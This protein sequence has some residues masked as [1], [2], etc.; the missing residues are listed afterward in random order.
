[1]TSKITLAIL[2]SCLVMSALMSQGA[3]TPDFSGTWNPLRGATPGGRKNVDF[4]A[5]DKVPFQ[6]AT[7]AKYDASKPLSDIESGCV[8]RGAVRYT[9]TAML[10]FDI[11]QTPQRAV[12]L[13][14]QH[15]AFRRIYTDGR[16]HPDNL[17]PTYFGHSIGR[18]EGTTLVVDTIGE[19]DTTWLNSGDHMLPH[20][21]AM[22][23]TERFRLVE[24][25]KYLEDEIT[26]ED[27]RAYTAP[28]KI[29]RYWERSQNIVDP[30]FVCEDALP[31]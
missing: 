13:F 31:Q 1:M 7:R 24:D 25:G 18:W 22:H 2:A 6:A 23:V 21:D 12:F 16:R 20:S 28:M 9:T 4:P 19:K 8:P 15:S 29:T 11:V 26:I 3:R 17:Q 5:A 10:P 14:N 30:E 27:A